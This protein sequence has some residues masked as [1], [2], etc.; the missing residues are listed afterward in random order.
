MFETKGNDIKLGVFFNQ[1]KKTPEKKK[2]NEAP[3]CRCTAK[4]TASPPGKSS[5][6]CHKP[7][8]GEPMAL[9]LSKRFKALAMRSSKHAGVGG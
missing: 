9:Q 5:V 1:N 8:S 2:K 7:L 4:A 6:T 3:D